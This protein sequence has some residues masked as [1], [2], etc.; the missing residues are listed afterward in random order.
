MTGTSIEGIYKLFIGKT[1]SVDHSKIVIQKAGLKLKDLI[2]EPIASAKAVLT[3]DDMEMGVA[4]IDM[5]GGTTDLLIYHNNIIRHTAVIPFGGNSITED[6][7]QGCNVSLK[8]AELI[9]TKYGSC[10][11]EYAPDN[12]SLTIPGT[13]VTENR[14]IPFKLIASIIEARVEELI[15]AIMYE[16]K[17]SGYIN[18]LGAG[19]VI[20]GGGSQLTNLRQLVKFTTGFSTR[21]ASPTINIT[22]DT[23]KHICKP[24]AATAF[25]LVMH[26]FEKPRNYIDAQPTNETL[27]QETEMEMSEIATK[28]TSKTKQKQIKKKASFKNAIDYIVGNIFENTNNEA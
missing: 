20:T 23:P 22:S 24:A 8:N 18:K 14:S 12:K 4:M 5:G 28:E 21:I 6:L 9:K 11:S 1:I 15:E 27:F 16:I 3:E 7:R 13:N 26:G 19:I 25:G 2:L 17:K 10:F